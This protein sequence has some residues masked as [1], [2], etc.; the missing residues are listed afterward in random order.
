MVMDYWLWVIEVCFKDIVTLSYKQCR[1]AMHCVSTEEIHYNAQ[2]L[3]DTQFVFDGSGNIFRIGVIS[4]HS[5]VED[6]GVFAVLRHFLD[7]I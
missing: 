6:V 2:K 7:G 4:T 1:D 5:N 3:F